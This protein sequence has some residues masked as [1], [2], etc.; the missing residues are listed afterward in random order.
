M[1]FYL[2]IWLYINYM[3]NG[4]SFNIPP[5]EARNIGPSYSQ[6]IGPS[7]SQVLK[8]HHLPGEEQYG[9]PHVIVEISYSKSLIGTNYLQS[10]KYSNK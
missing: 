10:G 4:P 8:P 1:A 6:Y 3:R 9:T 7:Y 2:T 5:T